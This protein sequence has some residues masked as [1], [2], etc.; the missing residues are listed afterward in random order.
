MTNEA[1]IFERKIKN[2]DR[3][4]VLD[5]PHRK[6]N[7]LSFFSMFKI[8]AAGDDT[9]NLKHFFKTQEKIRKLRG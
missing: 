9:N 1:F 4:K 3:N 6:I 8:M 7:A 5:S 2:K